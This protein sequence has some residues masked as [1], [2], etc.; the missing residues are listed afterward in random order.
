VAVYNVASRLGLSGNREPH[1]RLAFRL[2][3]SSGL[4]LDGGAVTVIDTNTFAG[5][6]LI[7]TIQPDESRLI[8]YAVDQGTSISSNDAFERQRVE[9]VVV[10]GGSLRLSYKMVEKTVYKIRNNNDAARILVLEVPIRN[11]WKLTSAPPEETSANFYRFRVEVKP[12]SATDFPVHEERPME[13]VFAVSSL[14]ANQIAVWARAG[15]L[16]AETEKE[17][18]EVADWQAAIG[19][20]EQEIAALEAERGGIFTDQE[21][22]RENLQ[23]LGQSPDEAKLRQRYVKQLDDQETRLAAIGTDKGKLEAEREMA[24][25]KLEEFIRKLSIDRKL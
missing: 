23:R 16:D 22:L 7:G 19:A 21:R 12:K 3:N 8:G 11:G 10:S 20:L 18:R 17:L 25:A 2:K 14:N 5:E 6:G 13:D 9:R 4:T 1:P 15:S 24:R